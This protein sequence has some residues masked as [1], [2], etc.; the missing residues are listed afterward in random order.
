MENRSIA[1]YTL[2]A[3]IC[4]GLGYGLWVGVINKGTFSVSST[5]PFSLQMDQNQE[6]ICQ[7]S[8]CEFRVK[9]GMHGVS[10][11]KDG[12]IEYTKAVDVLRGEKTEV[13]VE[14][15][16]I[17]KAETSKERLTIPAVRNPFVLLTDKTKGVQSLV[18]KTSGKADEVI[19]YFSRPFEQTKII[20]NNDASLVWIV[21]RTRATAATAAETSIYHIHTQQ[22]T[23]TLIYT[24]PEEVRGISASSSGKMVA[25][26]LANRVDLVDTDSKISL[27]MTARVESEKMFAWK[28][29]KS[30]VYTE[31]D[32][33]AAGSVF[34]KRATIEN[35]GKSD[36]IQAWRNGE[37]TLTQLYNDAAKSR[38]LVKGKVSDYVVAY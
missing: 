32:G 35:P 24:S 28:N 3:L 26:I 29:E 23:R 13:V 6:V 17:V 30:F 8:P 7:T 5:A 36:T 10:V 18:K 33:G 2:I 4:V 19:A 34:L 9:A 27:A 31:Q 15:E 25:V 21:N 1:I 38:L 20:T 12:F 22:K 37:E 16:K 14:L 11:R